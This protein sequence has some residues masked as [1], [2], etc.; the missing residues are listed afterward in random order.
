MTNNLR[1]FFY[2]S[3]FSLFN[4]FFAISATS[5]LL[6]FTNAVMSTTKA[7]LQRWVDF[8]SL[9]S[10]ILQHDAQLQAT[11]FGS[12]HN[13]R[14]GSQRLYRTSFKLHPPMVLEITAKHPQDLP[15]EA[16]MHRPSP[17]HLEAG[18]LE[19]LRKVEDQGHGF[20]IFFS[21]SVFEPLHLHQHFPTLLAELL[22]FDHPWRPNQTRYFCCHFATTGVLRASH[23]RINVGINA[24]GLS[25]VTFFGIKKNIVVQA[26]CDYLPPSSTFSTNSTTS[27]SCFFC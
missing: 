19:S 24:I 12:W 15:W 3:S 26:C 20:L 21:C 10:C 23:Q 2:T 22:R 18:T 4:T 16:E 25:L 9:N 5:L 13:A 17:D 6:P 7:Q 11:P 8:H 1:P 27:S 14:D